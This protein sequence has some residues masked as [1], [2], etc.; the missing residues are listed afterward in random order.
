MAH[1]IF[2][3]KNPFDSNSNLPSCL[4]ETQKFEDIIKNCDSPKNLKEQLFKLN[5][6][7]VNTGLNNEEIYNI[8][9]IISFAAFLAHPNEKL[10]LKSFTNM[11]DKAFYCI[12]KKKSRSVSSS[13][14][15]SDS[16]TSDS[17]S[18][19]EEDSP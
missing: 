2:H 12:F 14:S 16:Y 7:F 15:S 8:L 13:S 11:V 3:I 17:Y 9:T 6:K 10:N 1:T 19:E 5:K 4:S 18:S